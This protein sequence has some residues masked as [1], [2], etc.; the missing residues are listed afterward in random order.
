MAAAWWETEAFRFYAML[1]GCVLGM[2]LPK[3][4]RYFRMLATM[5]HEGGHV[6]TA[7]LLGEKPKKVSLFGDTSGLALVQT[8]ASWK[9][10]CV[11]L[12]GY[13]FPPLVAFSSFWALANGWVTEYLWT[14]VALTGIFLF[15]YIRNPFGVFWSLSFI[16]LHLLVVFK[17]PL[18]WGE[19][20]A[21]LDATVIFVDAVG[22]CLQLVR[23]AFRR[24][25]ASGDAYNI[26]RIIRIPPQLT[27][28][29]FTA[30]ALYM[31]YCCVHRFFPLFADIT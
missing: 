2:Y 29:G 20:L 4:G 12:A 7:L 18:F 10:L 26:S 5:V 15:C 25:E 30:F 9:A 27:A 19:F 31:D 21:R 14:V 17:A 23:V 24:P 16:A 13:P 11:A 1:G 22:A 3:V 6:L 28:L 8:T